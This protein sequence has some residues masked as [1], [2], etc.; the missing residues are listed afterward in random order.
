MV[1]EQAILGE[2]MEAESQDTTMKDIES[3][4]RRRHWPD[5]RSS[6]NASDQAQASDQ[7]RR[8]QRELVKCDLRRDEQ[9]QQSAVE[10]AKSAWA[11]ARRRSSAARFPRAASEPA[12]W[13]LCKRL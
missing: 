1:V 10:R 5:E 13:R 9:L 11:P 12:S 4:H 6:R 8:Q 2:T 3:G 7:Q